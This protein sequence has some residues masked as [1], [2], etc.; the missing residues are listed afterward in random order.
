MAW[1]KRQRPPHYLIVFPN[2]H[3]K[4]WDD[5]NKHCG[6]RHGAKAAFI[7]DSIKEKLEKEC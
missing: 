5:L 1:T 4:T 3:G 2:K 7:R 6:E